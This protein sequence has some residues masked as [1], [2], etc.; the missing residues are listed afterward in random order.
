MRPELSL[1]ALGCVLVAGEPLTITQYNVS[2]TVSGAGA[3]GRFVNG[4]WWI[5]G[6]A[7]LEAALPA[8]DGLRN[9]LEV[10]P[11]SVEQQGFDHRVAGWNASRTARLPLIVNPGDRLVKAAS[12]PPG[13]VQHR[14]GL[15][16]AIVVTVLSA[17]PP[18]GA[19]RPP[20][21]GRSMMPGPSG[22]YW[23]ASDANLS[24]LEARPVV[25]SDASAI[26][27]WSWLAGRFGRLQLDHLK[28]YAS[29]SLHPSEN[30]PNYG[31]DIAR[32]T[33]DG[34][35]RLMLPDALTNA[36]AA[37]PGLVAYLQMGLD[38]YGILS[39][40]GSWPANGGHEN[41]RK[42]PLAFAGV[43]LGDP[44]IV[45]ASRD[46]AP[47][48]FSESDELQGRPANAPVVLFG[49]DDLTPSS[50]SAE[51][52]YWRVVTTGD[53]FRTG[54][55]PYGWIDGGAFPSSYYQFCC[56]SEMWKG[57]SLPMRNLSAPLG[58]AGNLPSFHEYVDRWVAFGAWAQP[59]PCAPP[60]G[61]CSDGSGPCAGFLHSPC[62]A[63]NGTCALSMDGYGKAFGPDGKGGCIPDTDPSDGTG[64]FPS[65]HGA[66]RDQGDYVSAFAQ[67]MWRAQE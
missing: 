18:D 8:F 39:H 27:G 63:G 16:T 25:P 26:P 37:L 53:G 15:R 41:G 47:G 4:D 67:A 35:M 29:R 43:V 1:L 38:V 64:R 36:S 19:F 33:G 6:P 56:T 59:D 66:A 28:G 51:E 54:R 23:L 61:L 31:A 65:L 11:A 2:L 10:S 58:A 42:L 21:F 57:T 46:A 20:Y 17:P 24:R 30:M 50:V 5:V 22:D 34:A 7:T 44:S 48:A 62:G 3:S 32:D 49:Q 40:G 14:V 12:Q 45:A 13:P 9:G 52:E 55:D 60:T